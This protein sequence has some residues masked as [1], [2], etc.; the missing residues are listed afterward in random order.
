[1]KRRDLISHLTEEDCILYRE[2]GNHSVYFNED[3]GHLAA[4]PRHREI[5]INLVKRICRQLGI[6]LPK[7]KA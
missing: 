7:D 3:N 6:A 2:G 4:V 5:E 1:M